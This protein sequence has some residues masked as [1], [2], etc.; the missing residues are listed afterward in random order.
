VTAALLAPQAAVQPVP[1]AFS[2]REQSVSLLVL[3]QLT[4][5]GQTALVIFAYFFL[6]KNLSLHDTG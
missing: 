6:F 3:Q 2:F 5:M 1:L 4:I